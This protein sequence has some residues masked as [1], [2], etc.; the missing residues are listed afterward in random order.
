MAEEKENAGSGSQE[1]HLIDKSVTKVAY[2]LVI[3]YG[4]AGTGIIIKNIGK[5]ST[6]VDI[7]GDRVIGIYAFCDIRN[8]TD[9]TEVLQTKVMTFV[10]R[11][12]AVVHTNIVK[13][14]GNPNKNIGDAFLLVWKVTSFSEEPG[15]SC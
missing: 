5:Q 15:F 9:A 2:L 3:G 1:I 11:I 6:S 12:A 14:G 7:P 8:F 4:E 10:N 13:F